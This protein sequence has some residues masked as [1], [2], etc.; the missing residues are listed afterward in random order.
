ME[1]FNKNLLMRNKDKCLML[2][3]NEVERAGI[4]VFDTEE[5]STLDLKEN[6]VSSNTI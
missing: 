3:L 2:R 5:K 1:I 6:E 4:Q